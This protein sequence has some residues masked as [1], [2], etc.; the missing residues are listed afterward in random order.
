MIRVRDA[1]V[2]FTYGDQF[3]REFAAVTKKKTG[4]GTAYYI[5]C[6]LEEGITKLLMERMMRQCGISMLPSAEGVEIVNRGNE[7]QRVTMYMNHNSH[8]VTQGEVTLAPFE[9]KMIE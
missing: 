4:S 6:G 8:E 1:E 5:G 9:C 2:L 7:T 3:Y